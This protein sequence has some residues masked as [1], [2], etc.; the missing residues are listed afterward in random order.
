VTRKDS[1]IHKK[2]YHPLKTTFKSFK[3]F[4]K[5]KIANRKEKERKKEEG[6]REERK[7]G[8]KE[9]RRNDSEYRQ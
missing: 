6:G 1:K 3:E 9:E 7:K 5:E 4:S 8:R 2:G